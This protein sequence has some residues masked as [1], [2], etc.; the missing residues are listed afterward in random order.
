MQASATE[1]KKRQKKDTFFYEIKK[2]K[3]LYLLT[4]PGIL[5]YLVFH[6]IPMVGIVIAFQEFNPAKGIFGSKFV[7]LRNIQ[8]VIESGDM[9]RIVFNTL[10]LNILFIASGLIFA[11]GIA[12]FLNEIGNMIYKKVAQ[13]IVILPHFLSWTVVA[14]FVLA[15]FSDESGLVNRTLQ[16]LNLPTIPFYM[17]PAP[18]PLILVILRIWK[19]AGWGSIIYLATIAGIDPEIYEAAKIDGANRWQCMLRI[20]LPELKSPA[21][22][23]TLL[24]LGGIFHGDFGMIYAIIG[25]NSMLFPTTDVI[26]T[27]VFRA[28]RTL[29]DMGMSAAVGLFQSIVGFILVILVNAIARKLTPESAIF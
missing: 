15:F 12:L 29:G 22:L 3:V 25:D 27:Y 7:G 18:W 10:Y 21:V 26:D 4:L 20:T 24:G 5:F 2:N 23:L 1:Q 11:I 9:A 8:F 13:S 28:L 6:Y 19:G 17:D 14:M 16:S